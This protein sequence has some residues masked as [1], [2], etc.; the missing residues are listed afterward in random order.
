[1]TARAAVDVVV[2][3]AATI[4]LYQLARLVHARH[5]AAWLSPLLVAPLVLGAVLVA[6]GVA[7]PRYRDGAG[8]LVTMLGPTT[9]AFAV[10]IYRE[11][12]LLRRHWPVVLGGS[13]LASVTAIATSW[14]LA[15]ALGLDGV[16]RQSLVPR[17]VSTPFAME[18]SRRLGGAPDLT[19]SFVVA[20][21]VLG[22]VLGELM[23]A[24]LPV[25]S[26]LARGA[27]FGAGAH[28]AGTARAYQRDPTEGAVSALIMVTMGVLNVA[29]APL[30]AWLL[31][32]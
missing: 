32:G 5:R 20:T 28:G 13:V 10:P 22:A 2:W 14:W 17:S 4:G 6:L 7:Y 12:A 27:V 24:R 9:V 19:A 1:M 30:L 16:V 31:P 25:R 8:W 29:C 21:G 23:L 15:S 26:P 11:R 3:S 18:V